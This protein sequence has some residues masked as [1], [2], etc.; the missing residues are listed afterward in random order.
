MFV[1][2]SIIIG[3]YTATFINLT[4]AGVTTANIASK[5]FGRTKFLPWDMKFP[6][7]KCRNNKLKEKIWSKIIGRNFA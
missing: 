5:D 1:T 6:H 3:I 7:T 2:F 4:C